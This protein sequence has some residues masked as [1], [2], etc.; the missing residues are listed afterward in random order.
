[1]QNGPRA[2]KAAPGGDD[3][4]REDGFIYMNIRSYFGACLFPKPDDKILDMSGKPVMHEP[5]VEDL[6]ESLSRRQI[7][8]TLAEMRFKSRKDLRKVTLDR[9]VRDFLVAALKRETDGV[10]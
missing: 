4:D 9:G 10:T 8:E 6:D 7:V 5:D 3:H 2:D 1:M